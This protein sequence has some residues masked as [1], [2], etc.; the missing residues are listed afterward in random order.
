MATPEEKRII[1]RSELQEKQRQERQALQEK[2]KAETERRQRRAA[3][4]RINL[5]KEI[6]K[7]HSKLFSE[8]KKQRDALQEKLKNSRGIGNL[9]RGL[10]GANNRDKQTLQALRDSLK[11]IK[12]A[13]ETKRLNLA[14]EQGKETQQ[15]QERHKNQDNKLWDKQGRE[16]DNLKNDQRDKRRGYK[17]I[18]KEQDAPQPRPRP[19]LGMTHEKPAPQTSSFE[20]QVKPIE[21][22]DKLSL[23]RSW[24]EANE[25]E[26]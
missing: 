21:R 3:R 23:R 15:E 5:E 2:Q 16:T 8:Q 20:Q 19:P 22:S 11:N 18:Q 10:S 12:S 6:K 7:Q 13:V 1:E 24:K 26:R 17:N 14:L 4:D 9:A 25:P